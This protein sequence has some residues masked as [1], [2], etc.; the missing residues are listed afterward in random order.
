MALL[1]LTSAQSAVA[2][3]GP[4]KG[5]EWNQFINNYQDSRYQAASTVNSSNVASLTVAWS[6]AAQV[7][8]TATPAV[9]NGSVYFDDW[10]GYVYSLSLATGSLNWKVKLP[11]IFTSSPALSN[12]LVYVAGGNLTAGL[13]PEV[14]ALTAKQGRVAWTTVLNTTMWGVFASPIV[15]RGMVYVG[16]SGCGSETGQTCKGKVFALNAKTGVVV[17]SFLTGGIAGGAGVWGSVVVDSQLDQLYFGTGNSYT[18]NGTEGYAYSIVSLNAT[19]GSLKWYYQLY[20]SPIVGGDL[21]FGSTPNLFTV[22]IRGA[23]HKAVGLGSKNGIFY[24]WDR[25][26]G[27]SLENATI[28]S[29]LVQGSIIGVAGYMT[30]ANN[31]PACCLEVFVP[32]YN[33]SVGISCCGIVVALSP[34][35]NTFAWRFP[36]SG[37]VIGSVAEVPGAVIFGDV[38]GN[39]YAVSSILG[40]LLFKTTLPGPVEAG[41]TPAEGNVTVAAGNVVYSFVP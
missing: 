37:Q 41:A 11:S 16:T 31:P 38:K 20:K 15:F 10:G 24:I 39:L 5:G 23:L 36:A 4:P 12:G 13:K 27:A 34:T 21:D 18:T 25:V 28:S 32:A 2:S 8:V 7:A 9:N 14:V 35:S 19:T 1:I 17:W 29:P 33:G 26:S 6:F 3:S 30:A 22:S 40:T